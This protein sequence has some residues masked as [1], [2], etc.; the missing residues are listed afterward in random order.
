MDLST[1][2]QQVTLLAPEECGYIIKGTVELIGLRSY[3]TEIHYRIILIKPPCSVLG[4]SDCENF[5]ISRFLN[6]TYHDCDI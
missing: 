6:L 3:T 4:L 5:D 1:N 2:I